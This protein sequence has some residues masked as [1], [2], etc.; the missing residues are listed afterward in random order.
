M[1][2]S[3]RAE[4]EDRPSAMGSGGKAV[5]HARQGGDDPD[6]ARQGGRGHRHLPR[7][8]GAASPQ[9]LGETVAAFTAFYARDYHAR[10][11]VHN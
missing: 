6:P 11:T 4:E 2:E 9:A 5:R 10:L 1:I 3:A 8:G 7:L